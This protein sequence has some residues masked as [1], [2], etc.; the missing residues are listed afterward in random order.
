MKIRSRHPKSSNGC[1]LCCAPDDP[2][3]GKTVKPA[4]FG[5]AFAPVCTLMR[6][7]AEKPGEN[8][9]NRE[10]KWRQMALF[11]GSKAPFRRA[12]SQ[13]RQIATR[14]SARPYVCGVRLRRAAS[15]PGNRRWSA[16]FH[17][18]GH[19]PTWASDD[20][21]A[22]GGFHPPYTGSF[23]RSLNRVLCW[24]D[25]RSSARRPGWPAAFKIRTYVVPLDNIWSGSAFRNI[26][27]TGLFGVPRSGRTYVWKV[28]AWKW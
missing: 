1:G 15:G 17:G 16:I 13:R 2:R 6:K 18:R 28:G 4:L 24:P 7:R 8:R 27:P 19:G 14:Q 26:C 25:S 22:D 20:R 3:P 21:R 23:S 11:R 9:Q 12:R 10:G 5:A